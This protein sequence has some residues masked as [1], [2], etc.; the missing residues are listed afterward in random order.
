MSD[1][2]FH[3]EQGSK[4]RKRLRDAKA[5]QDLSTVIVTPSR[6][7]GMVPVRVAA[8]HNAL[9][10]PMNQIVVPL[11]VSGMEVGAAYQWAFD[12][13]LNEPGFAGF[14]YVLTMEDDNLP[15][16]DGLLKLYEHIHEYAAVGGLYWT[17]GEAGMP[18]IYGDP[19]GLLNFRPQVP[20]V[21]T[22]QECNGL[23]MG[24]TLFRLD[25]FRDGSLGPPPWFRTIQ[26]WGPEGGKAY[27]QDLAAF[28]RIRKAGHRVACDTRVK[29]GHYDHAGTYGPA[30]MVW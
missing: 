17:K 12:T 23:G 24:F 25:V 15:P 3:N 9:M 4:A 11:P 16:P 8:A 26:E 27:T 20:R 7:D 13:I 30:G 14:R 22:V 5:Y 1:A 28:E 19:T 18:M 6:A 29:V 10:R 21:D 2:G